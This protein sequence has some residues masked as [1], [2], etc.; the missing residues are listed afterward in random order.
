MDCIGK[1]LG[2]AGRLA[3]PLQPG[4]IQAI[5]RNPDR[6]L[7]FIK[8]SVKK[9]QCGGLAPIAGK[10]A[11]GFGVPKPGSS[12]Q[13]LP[14][15]GDGWVRDVEQHYEVESQMDGRSFQYREVA[16]HSVTPPRKDL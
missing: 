16:G 13:V 12:P 7:L 4:L 11:E 9:P 10:V 14:G 15:R 1:D 2:V 8:M 5:D 6:G 3:Q